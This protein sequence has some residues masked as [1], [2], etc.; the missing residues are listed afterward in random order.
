MTLYDESVRIVDGDCGEE[1]E[2]ENGKGEVDISERVE[3][4]GDGRQRRSRFVKVSVL[5]ELGRKAQS[6]RAHS[7]EGLFAKG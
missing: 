2:A 1:A 3:G 7:F 6:W 4:T 5:W